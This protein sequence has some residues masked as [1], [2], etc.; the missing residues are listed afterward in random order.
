MK[1]VVLMLAGVCLLAGAAAAE[2]LLVN[3]DF[4]LPLDQGWS[5]DVRTEAGDHS[6]DRWD[7]LGQPTP[8]YAARVYKYLARYASL[9][10]VCDVP[11]VDLEFSFD[12]RFW[13]EGGSTTCWPTGAVIL[14]Y[15]D[16]TDAELGCTMILLRN[17]FNDW[18]ESDTMN[19]YD[20]Q[21][22]GEWDSFGFSVAQEIEDN[23]PGVDAAEVSGV[24][25]QLFSYCNGT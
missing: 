8:G 7:T 18:V 21:V 25:V 10:Q 24:K 13:I 12:G 14:S 20:V 6:F 19:F 4:E 15:L 23:L 22:P 16:G 2:N 5:E 1:T 3:G 11:G 9:Y 17:Q